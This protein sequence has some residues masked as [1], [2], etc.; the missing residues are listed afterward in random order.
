MN[1]RNAQ[2]KEIRAAILEAEKVLIGIGGEWQLREDGKKVRSRSLKDEAQRALREG[3]E[4]LYRLIRDKDYYIVTTLADGAIYDTELDPS[5]I[6]APCGNIHWR[7]CSKACTKDIWEEG[8]VPS[9]V[10]PHCGAPMTGNTLEA[11][12]YIEEGYLPR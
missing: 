8:E 5:R 7:Q 6:V 1:D 10:C 9:D 2:K 3:Y 4:S 12:T 11:E